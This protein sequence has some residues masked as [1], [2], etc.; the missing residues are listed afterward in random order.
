[1]S[2][3]PFDGA[4]SRDFEIDDDMIVSASMI[5]E[6]IGLLPAASQASFAWLSNTGVDLAAAL[7]EQETKRLTKRDIR[8]LREFADAFKTLE[9]IARRFD[10]SSFDKNAIESELVRTS[11]DICGDYT[12][13]AVQLEF[14]LTGLFEELLVVAAGGESVNTDDLAVWMDGRIDTLK[15][16]DETKA[17][18]K[19][20]FRD[21][22]QFVLLGELS[23]GESDDIWEN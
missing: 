20:Y 11:N 4:F 19:L 10:R 15:A 5:T 3:S 7:L 2:P 21:L 14:A 9:P 22:C 8:Q 17:L 6:L 18:F 23:D 16:D 1:M 13:D 12:E